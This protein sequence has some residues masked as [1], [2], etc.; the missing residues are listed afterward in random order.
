MAKYRVGNKYSEGTDNL[1]KAG[2]IGAAVGLVCAVIFSLIAAAVISNADFGHRAI[3]PVSMVILALS[4]FVAG[5]VA[6]AI[7]HRRAL[8]VGAF[9][10]AILTSLVLLGGFF[11]P[12][13]SIGASPVL[14]VA[15]TAVPALVGAVISVNIPRKDKF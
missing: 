7:H 8:I 13:E 5:I 3:L 9:V 15:V 12:D 1:V 2:V 11:L 6:G 4:S 10:A 14:K